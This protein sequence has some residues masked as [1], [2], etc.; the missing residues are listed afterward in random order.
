ML[1]DADL[2]KS[3]KVLLSRFMESCEGA[4]C[5]CSHSAGHCSSIAA[6][7]E[8]EIRGVKSFAGAFTDL[9]RALQV[10][11]PDPQGCLLVV[12][13][14]LGEGDGYACRVCTSHGDDHQF[15]CYS[16]LKR[17][18]AHDHAPCWGT[19]GS[20]QRPAVTSETCEEDLPL[21]AIGDMEPLEAQFEERGF[22]KLTLTV[23]S[24]AG[25]S[26]MSQKDA[27]EYPVL[28]SEGQ[29]RGQMCV[30]AGGERMPNNGE[31]I[32]P[33]MTMDSTARISTFQNVDVR[34]P[35]LTVSATCDKNQLVIFDNDGSAILNRDSPEG[36]EIRRLLKSATD[37][38]NLER[39]NWIYTLPTWII[40]PHKISAADKRK[41]RYDRSGD[42]MMGELGTTAGATAGFHRQGPRL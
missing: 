24:G 4:H 14:D 21:Y 20:W 42:T 23:D 12:E 30:G 37:K 6:Q 28:P 2:D 16:A 19:L 29:A 41:I 18:C 7:S 1:K 27:P 26:A 8:A 25:K 38:L 10:H 15:S 35:L 5:E 39:K 40:P 22:R 36:R 33:L 34:K 31:Q 17:H 11:G 3:S 9:H 32:L 13:E